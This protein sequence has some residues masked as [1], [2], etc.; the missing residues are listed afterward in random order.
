MELQ[1]ALHDHLR[2][3]LR[4][5]RQ[6]LYSTARETRRIDREHSAYKEII[7]QSRDTLRDIS[8]PL[9]KVVEKKWSSDPKLFLAAATQKLSV[10]ELYR[11]V[12]E[13]A[14]EVLPEDDARRFVARLTEKLLS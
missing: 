14:S 8:P 2:K 5:A 1:T 13:T 3:V 7:E 11:L 12:I 10:V 9:A 6:Q 4:K